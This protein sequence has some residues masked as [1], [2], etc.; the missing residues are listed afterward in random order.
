MTLGMFTS[1]LCSIYFPDSR[2]QR[3][4]L[5]GFIVADSE[6]DIHKVDEAPDIPVGESEHS[7]PDNDVDPAKEKYDLSIINIDISLSLLFNLSRDSVREHSSS[8]K[9][10]TFLEDF[11]TRYVVRYEICYLY[12]STFIA[13]TLR[14]LISHSSM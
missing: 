2:F 6:D 11:P 3:S 9:N 14:M 10:T 8:H 5:G 1:L 12:L 7:I 13:L 4:D